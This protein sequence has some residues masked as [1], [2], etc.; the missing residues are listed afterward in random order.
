MKRLLGSLLL[1]IGN[2]WVTIS[3]CATMIV[4][5]L[6]WL[7][8]LIFLATSTW[9]GIIWAGLWLFIGGGIVALLV[10]LVSLPTRLFGASL[11]VLG[12][13]LRNLEDGAVDEPGLENCVACGSKRVS[14]DD[15][16]CRACGAPYG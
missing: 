14:K 1:V 5:F 3:T 13:R 9:G 10:G 16:F 15:Q 2:V 12:E 4:G 8:I 6:L 7:G 11:V